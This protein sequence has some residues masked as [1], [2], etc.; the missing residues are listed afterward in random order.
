VALAEFRNVFTIYDELPLSVRPT[1]FYNMRSA[2]LNG[3]ALGVGGMFENIAAKILHASPWQ[4]ALMT[5]MSGAGMVLAFFWGGFAQRRRKMPFVFWPWVG[6]SAVFFLLG[7]V[8]QPTGFCLLAG[9]MGFIGQVGAPAVAG[10]IRSNYPSRLRGMITGFTRRWHM[11]IAAV[12]GFAGAE[13]VE[14]YSRTLPGLYKAI[15]PVG[16]LCSLA[17]AFVFLRIRVRGEAGLDD[18]DAPPAPFKPFEPFMVLVRDKR[19]RTYMID[20]F[21]FGLANLMLSPITP[22]VLRDDLQADFRQMQWTT[23]VIPTVLGILTVGLWGRVLDR[24][25]P[26]TMRG[27]MNILWALLPLSYFCAFFV[28]KTS[29][30]FEL[31]WFEPWTWHVTLSLPVV[32]VWAGSFFMGTVAAGQ[33]L[34]WTLGAMYFAKKEDVPLYQG[35]HI[36][37]TGLRSLGGAFLGPLAVVWFGCGDP[38]AGRQRLYLFTT[39]C[40][41]LSGLLM[42]RLAERIRRESGGRLPSLAEKEAAEEAGTAGVPTT[43]DTEDTEDE[44]SISSPRA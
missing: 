33:G 38:A 1:Y 13:L 27:W 25:N 15:L 4:L 5:S 16:G 24:S 42:F 3:V 37:L 35:V 8:D 32:T 14:H 29:L 31:G 7:M 11:L 2:L 19:F 21:I 23:F 17:A 34:I 10:I 30:N 28:P 9:G 18:E 41:V 36:G 40:M 43:E 12:V 6:S 20:F 22:I 26:I 39:V 44:K